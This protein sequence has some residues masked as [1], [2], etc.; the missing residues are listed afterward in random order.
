MTGRRSRPHLPWALG[1]GT[2]LIVFGSLAGVLLWHSRP[3]ARH[4]VAQKAVTS[5]GEDKDTVPADDEAPGR[6]FRRVPPPTPMPE[7]RPVATVVRFTDVTA[8]SGITFV[9]TDGS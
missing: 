6:P 8:S 5:P 4:G 2:L 1:I 3:Q 9:H 7:D